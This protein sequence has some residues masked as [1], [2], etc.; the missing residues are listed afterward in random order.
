MPPAACA[1]AGAV[2]PPVAPGVAEAWPRATSSAVLV[3][4]PSLD[5]KLSPLSTRPPV[6]DEGPNGPGPTGTPARAPCTLPYDF[7]PV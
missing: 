4:G 7:V 1:G 2:C 3:H 5:R 6:K